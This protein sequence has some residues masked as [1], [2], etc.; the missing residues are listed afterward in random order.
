VTAVTLAAGLLCAASLLGVVYLILAGL[1]VRAFLCGS[2]RR[3]EARPPVSVLKPLHGADYELEANLRQFCSL[4]YP[5]YQIVFGV[6]DEADAA[7]PIVQAL[8]KQLPQA[9]I[10]LVIDGRLYGSNGKISNLINMLGA[11]R[12]DMLVISD[13][14]MRVGADYLDPLVAELERPGVG[15]VTCLYRG[16]AAPGLWSQLGAM[17]ISFGFLPSVL[18]GRWLGARFGCFGATMALS[19]RTLEAAGGLEGLKDILAD[20]YAL[21]AKVRALG[22]ELVLCRYLPDTVME[23]PSFR[24]LMAHEL[25]WARTMRG[26]A[27]VGYAASVVTMPVPLALLAALLLPAA[28]LPVL[29]LCLAVRLLQTAWLARMLAVPRPAAWLVPVRDLLSFALVIA[30]FCGSAISWRDQRFRVDAEGRL[31]VERESRA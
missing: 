17:F 10:A 28:G 15:I 18:L 26:I 6:Q 20:D 25:R 5:E 1:A 16:A 27:P 7:V 19:R 9:D 8:I 11:A 12:H 24:H 30:S 3:P 13:S 29:A 14:D 4:A 2:P 22:L 31:S 21:G 23:E